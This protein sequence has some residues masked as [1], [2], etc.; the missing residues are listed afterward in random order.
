M[1]RDPLKPLALTIHGAVSFSGLSRSR[2]YSFI[3][4]NELPSFTV[5]GRRMILTDEIA[6]LID[7]LARSA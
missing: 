6:A 7:R 4:A 2:L 3:Q 1:Q 5:G